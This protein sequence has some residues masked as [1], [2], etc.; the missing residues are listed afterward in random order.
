MK[1][2]FLIICLIAPYAQAMDQGPTSI[3]MCGPNEPARL[4]NLRICPQW[5]TIR[6]AGPQ[7]ECCAAAC[8]CCCYIAA[9]PIVGAYSVMCKKIAEQPTARRME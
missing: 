2:L 7:Y 8:E 4:L 9:A 6:N 3:L 1:K 5:R